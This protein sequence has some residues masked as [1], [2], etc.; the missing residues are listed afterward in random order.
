MNKVNITQLYIVMLSVLMFVPSVIAQNYDTS[1][2]VTQQLAEKKNNKLNTSFDVVFDD[3]FKL[4]RNDMIIMTPVLK[5]N[6][7]EDSIVFEPIVLVGKVR[8]KVIRRNQKYGNA[9]PMPINVYSTLKRKNSSEQHMAYASSVDYS[10]WMRNA[11]LMLQNTTSGCADCESDAGIVPISKRLIPSLSYSPS[12]KIKYIVPDVELV[13]ERSDKHT[14]TF[15]FVVNRY[16]LLRDYKNNRS[17]FDDVDKIIRDIQSDENIEITEFNI[18]GYAS[19]EASFAHNKTLAENRAK[20]FADYLVTKLN[21]GR[22]KFKVSS[23]GEDW[24]GLRKAVVASNISDKDEILNIID[25]VDDPDARD[26]PLKRLSNGTTYHTLLNELYPPLRRTE[27]TIAYVVRAFDVDEAKE[28]IKTN[29]KQLSLNEMFIVAE[30]YPVGSSEFN[31]VFD[32][33]LRTFPDSEISVANA[34]A[35][36]IESGHYESAIKIMKNSAYAEKMPNNLAIAYAGVGNFDEARKLFAK[37]AKEGYTD[38][39]HNLS[40]LNKHIE[41][42][43]E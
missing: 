7:S 4:G 38:A 15:N 19:P 36:Q 34:A 39:A 5:S 28:I 40:E 35:A 9:S 1:I 18:E 32:I 41:G 24:V 27:Y 26:N 8:D 22:D 16:E 43:E 14:A 13:K 20:S 23:Y 33:A 12:Y 42:L 30:T 6:T 11:Q 3:N 37:A 2:K 25:T 21:V 10:P 29:P 31:E 17:K